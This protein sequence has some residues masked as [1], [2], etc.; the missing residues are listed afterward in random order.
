[1]NVNVICLSLCLKYHTDC[2]GSCPG[3]EPSAVVV[4]AI[5][6]T[7]AVRPVRPAGGR[8]VLRRLWEGLRYQRRFEVLFEDPLYDVLMCNNCLDTI[9]KKSCDVNILFSPDRPDCVEGR[10]CFVFY[11][12]LKNLKEV[13]ICP[14]QG[15]KGP[16][17]GQV[18]NM[19]YTTGNEVAGNEKYCYILRLKMD[20]GSQ[21]NQFII[22]GSLMQ[23]LFDP[24]NRAASVAQITQWLYFV[25]LFQVSF[26]RGDI[27][28]NL[29]QEVTRK[30]KGED[31][32]WLATLPLRL[33]VSGCDICFSRHDTFL[34]SPL[35]HCSL[36]ATT[37]T[38]AKLTNHLV[39][40]CILF[41]VVLL[42]LLSPTN[43]VKIGGK[44]SKCCLFFPL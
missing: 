23:L 6:W 40:I 31:S 42:V 39:V 28:S 8:A 14:A 37:H 3:G 43:N 33:P 32:Q 21:R 10:L 20:T 36:R 4:T 15:Q 44:H 17:R 34:R 12:S 30:R 16:V 18:R 1:M 25:P 35:S 24:M 13:Y 41:S 19:W 11:S 2:D 22:A 5:W 7:P 38:L 9:Y 27:P 26:Y 29:P